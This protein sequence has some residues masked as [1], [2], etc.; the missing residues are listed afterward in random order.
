MI[1]NWTVDG[2]WSPTYCD[3]EETDDPGVDD[4]LYIMVSVCVSRFFLIFVLKLFF[5][6]ILLIFLF[7]ILLS[8]F[9]NFFF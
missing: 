3:H 6:L 5:G 2:R 1:I 8:N 9:F 4:D 7:E